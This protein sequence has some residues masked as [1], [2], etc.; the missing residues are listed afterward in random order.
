MT[1]LRVLHFTMFEA[2]FRRVL[3]QNDHR[4]HVC[5]EHTGSA[6]LEA[7]G[8]DHLAGSI[9]LG[10]DEELQHFTR[11]RRDRK[12]SPPVKKICGRERIPS[13][14]LRC[15]RSLSNLNLDGS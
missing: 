6:R 5:D 1:S 8:P 11:L 13:L 3:R 12:I 7:F 9:T 2:V 4:S 15:F 14:T 10:M